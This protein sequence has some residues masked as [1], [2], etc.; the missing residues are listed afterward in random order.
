MYINCLIIL[1]Y[2]IFLFTGDF[3]MSSKAIVDEL[4]KSL[5]NQ[6]VGNE[7]KNF[8]KNFMEMKMNEEYKILVDAWATCNESVTFITN[9][10]EE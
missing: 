4:I 9:D 8:F 5:G 3:K 10:A 1:S 7:S 6:L 2:N